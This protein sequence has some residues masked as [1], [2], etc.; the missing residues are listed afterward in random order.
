MSRRSAK[1]LWTCPECG[2]QFVSANTQH[3]CGRYTLED[4]FAGKDP[5]VREL[6]DHLLSVLQTFGPVT[7][8]PVKTRII[9]QAE[10]QFAAAMPRKRW[11]DGYLWLRRRAAH[12]TI[13]RV[14]MQVF[15]D[16][17][18]VFR[19]TKP[20]DLDEAFVELLQEAFM[21]GSQA[22]PKR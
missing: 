10:T 2:R 4:H 17:G 1:P 7:V 9:F 5:A 21:L 6:F 16:Y 11:L 8:H 13:Q 18:H 22:L 15:R 14:E 20:S 12:P 19:L 3:S